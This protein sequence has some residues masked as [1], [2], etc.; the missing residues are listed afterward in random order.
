MKFESKLNIGDF[1]YCEYNKLCGKIWTIQ[2]HGEDNH[3]VYIL[4]SGFKIYEMDGVIKLVPEVQPCDSKG[5]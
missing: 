4:E 3:V 5:C 2:F 1:A